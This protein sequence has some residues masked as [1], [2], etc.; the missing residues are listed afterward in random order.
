MNRIELYLEITKHLLKDG[1]PSS[2]LNSLYTEPLFVQH[3]F[4]M[5]YKLKSTQQSPI[6]H[7]EGNV[8]NHVML[9][10]DQAAKIKDKSNDPI[11]FMWAALLHDIGKPS[12]TRKRKGRITSYDHDVIGEKLA[13]EFLSE[14]T[15]D[16]SF[17]KKV[18]K[19]V[20]YHMHILYVNKNLPFADI[21]NMKR[22]TDIYEIA[23]LGLC[24]RMGRTN[25]NATIEKEN[26]K[27]FLKK[28]NK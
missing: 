5:L 3:P 17:I 23:L 1:K 11:A 6:H 22:D 10:V 19:L 20:R 12:T 2:Y 14:F 16:K 25:S 26:I 13:I 21:S 9:V 15:N 4:D 7:P 8:W 28:L 27:K 24:D 18:S